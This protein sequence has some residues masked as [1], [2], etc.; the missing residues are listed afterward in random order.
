MSFPA[1][2]KPRRFLLYAPQRFGP[3]TSKTANAF[4]RYR[5]SEVVAVLDPAQAGKMAEQV[6]GFG[7]AVPVVADLHQALQ[8]NPD[9][10][11]IGIAPTGGGLDPDWRPDLQAAL[12]AGLEVWNGLH[13]FL[14]D[15]PQFQDFA[16]QIWD[17]RRPPEELHVARGHWKKRRSRVILTVGSDANVGK[18]TAAIQLQR[19]LAAQGVSSLFIGTGQTGIALSG[20]GVAVDAVVSDF[21]AGA[22]EAELDKVDGQ[23]QV[24]IV[25]GQGALN[26]IGFSGVTLGLLHGCLPD[27]MIFCHQP[28]RLKNAYGDPIPPLR[29][30]IDWHESL[31]QPFKPA[32]VLGVA[33][34]LGPGSPGE[35]AAV[36]AR[37]RRETG[38]PVEDLVQDPTGVL[39]GAIRKFFKF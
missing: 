24:L 5:R 17:L 20:R 31:L 11:V 35:D 27:A 22:I 6:V 30:L 37:I 19:G 7:G 39:I 38:L 15:D 29:M 10:L 12:E 3:L 25:E 2:N 8:L 13:H 23:A 32:K 16:H 9:V 33:L 4:L 18:M 1:P 34:M 21:V 26:H 28:D 36:K 14:A